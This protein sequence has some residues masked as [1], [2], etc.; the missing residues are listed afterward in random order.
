[1][2]SIISMDSDQL[3]FLKQACYDLVTC[4]PTVSIHLFAIVFSKSCLKPCPN[5]NFNST[6]FMVKPN[7]FTSKRCAFHLIDSVACIKSNRASMVKL[8]KYQIVLVRFNALHLFSCVCVRETERDSV[9][10][11]K[12]YACVL[13]KSISQYYNFARIMF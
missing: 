6:I 5:T 8:L 7:H 10:L 1:M 13:R 9:C 3:S 11:M 2:Y 12:L 4:V